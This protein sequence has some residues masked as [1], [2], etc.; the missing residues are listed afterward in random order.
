MK[1]ESLRPLNGFV[2]LRK[3]ESSRQTSGGLYLP[4]D[5]DRNNTGEGAGVVVAVSTDP[6][7]IEKDG[8]ETFFF[9]ARDLRVGDRVVHRGFMRHIHAIGAMFGCQNHDEYYLI[10][11]S[12]I[13]AVVEGDSI[14]LGK[15]SEYRA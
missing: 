4:A 11:T 8:Q 3:A 14:T 15:Y 5:T 1:P 13:L 9:P 6:Q 7:T 2:L 10:K 12:D